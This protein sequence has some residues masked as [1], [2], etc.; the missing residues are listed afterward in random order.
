MV[1]G[2]E[3][4][5]LPRLAVL[6]EKIICIVKVRDLDGKSKGDN[7]LGRSIPVRSGISRRVLLVW[8]GNAYGRK[9]FLG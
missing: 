4:E 8:L 2:G 3:S 9:C 7:L 1:K 6:I 5:Q